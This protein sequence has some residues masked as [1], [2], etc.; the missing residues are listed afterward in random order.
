MHRLAAGRLDRL[1]A[2]R[3]GKPLLCRLELSFGVDQ[4]VRRGHHGFT[5]REAL[6]YLNISASAP[7][8]LDLARLKAPLALVDQDSSTCAIVEFGAFRARGHRGRRARLR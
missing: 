8:D 4:E 5:F 6:R 1:R 3:L 7:A 2:A